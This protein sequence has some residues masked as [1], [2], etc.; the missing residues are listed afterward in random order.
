MPAVPVRVGQCFFLIYI[1]LIAFFFLFN[2]F[3]TYHGKVYTLL[4]N[5]MVEELTFKI[6]S[7][8]NPMP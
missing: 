8:S 4:L 2:E 6:H 7:H 3:C 5:N 1:L